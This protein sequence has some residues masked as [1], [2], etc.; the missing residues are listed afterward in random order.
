MIPNENYTDTEINERV[1]AFYG[2][3]APKSPNIKKLRERLQDISY[4]MRS[5][6]HTFAVG[7]NRRHSRKGHFWS[8]RFGSVLIESG[9]SLLSC[10]G[11]I[12]LNP[13][14]ARIVEKP[15]DYRWCSLNHRVN[16]GNT[17]DLL[18]FAGVFDDE[19]PKTFAKN[20]RIYREFVYRSGGIARENKGKI[21][22]E[23]IDW[24]EK[25]GFMFSG[26][27]LF[28]KRLHHFTEGLVL[29]SQE[30]IRKAYTGV[31]SGDIFKQRTM[32]CRS[33][34][35]KNIHWVRR[36]KPGA[37]DFDPLFSESGPPESMPTLNPQLKY[38]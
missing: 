26:S 33:E 27:E 21:S 3:Y 13:V 32:E 37:P 11:Y 7:Y 30:F 1:K 22:Q 34:L 6:K 18:S 23:L 19:T 15:E 12:D 4:F 10:L 38:G 8:E 36:Q 5:V 31:M 14:R 2:K 16:K 29:G 20:L 24:E 17:D 35:N 25:R 9:E 28:R